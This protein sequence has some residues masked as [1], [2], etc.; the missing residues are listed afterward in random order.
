VASIEPTKREPDG[1]PAKDTKWR[2]RYRD[3]NGR[4]RRQ[5]FD[6]KTD[7]EAFLQ[8]TGVDVRAGDWIDPALRR[9]LFDDW[10]EAW[11]KTTVKLAPTT[12]R[13]YHQLLHNQVLPEFTGRKLA[14]IDFMDVE[15]FIAD[16]LGKGLSPKV[17]RD[18]VSVASLIIDCAV[19]SK[20]RR[21]NPAR[22]H[23]IP[24]RQK[25]L[26]PGDVPDMA[27]LARLVAHTRAP[28]RPAVWLLAL[29]GIRPSELAGLRVGSID[30][31]RR[32]V[33]VHTGLVP[34]HRFG[35]E[36][37]RLVEGPTKTEAGDRDIPIPEWLCQS[38]ATMLEERAKAGGRSVDQAEWLF[39]QPKGGPLNVKWF[40]EFVV[41]PALAAAGL[42][43]TLRTYD[44]R[45]SHAS[46]LI[47]Q[48]AKPAAVAHRLGHSDPAMTARVYTHLFEGVQEALTD[49]LDVLA[50]AAE[51]A[52]AQ[53]VVVPLESTERARESTESR[54][55]AP[56]PARR[57]P[58]KKAG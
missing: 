10:A 8:R 44:V 54:P 15:E 22:G 31:V 20:V 50:R 47:D 18:A 30:F 58:T 23:T 2:A 55:T 57:R 16:L 41:R 46:I 32:R 28:Y 52:L 36:P 39:T 53:P 7:A 4:S 35:D 33:A 56:N 3:P 34:V 21:D 26:R 12:R 13:R 17:V 48:G 9:A 40:R 14:G 5:V 6:R 11:W 42:P 43:E 1:R 25:K 37:F 45:H 24:R 19:K 29:T 51:A 49:Q 38:L 27:G